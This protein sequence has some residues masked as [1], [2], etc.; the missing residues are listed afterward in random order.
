MHKNSIDTGPLRHYSLPT[1][2]EIA[3]QQIILIRQVQLF[4]GDSTHKAKHLQHLPDEKDPKH[5][6]AG[7]NGM[8]GYGVACDAE[9]QV[10]ELEEGIVNT[11]I[12]CP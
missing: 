8:P 4:Q 3:C 1:R 12:T 7:E 10:L 6:G 9:Q 5:L 2:Q 11:V